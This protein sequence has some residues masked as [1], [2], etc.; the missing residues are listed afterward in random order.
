MSSQAEMEK[1]RRTIR[2]VKEKKEACQ[3][4]SAN[5]FEPA[6][7]NPYY[8]NTHSIR[9]L[10][11]LMERLDAFT[12]DEAHWLASWIEYLGDNKSA[13]WIRARPEKFKEIIR[14]RYNELN[15]FY[16]PP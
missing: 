15:E 10:A 2:R 14:D 5:L 8:H 16:H 11:E 1:K 12:N 7:K 3:K 13:A 6:G 9:N 4:L